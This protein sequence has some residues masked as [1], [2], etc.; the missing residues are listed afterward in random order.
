ML[1]PI[2]SCLS[3]RAL[4]VVMIA[5]PILPT[6]ALTPAILMQLGRSWHQL[7]SPT[8]LVLLGAGCGFWAV[9]V[10]LAAAGRLIRSMRALVAGGRRA[11]PRR[12]AGGT[13]A[14]A[15][16]RST[17]VIRSMA[18]AARSLGERSEAVREGGGGTAR[19]RG[20]IARLRRKRFGLVLGKRPRPSLL[21]SLRSYPHVRPGSEQPAR[22]HPLGARRRTATATP[23]NGAITG[24]CWSVTSRFAI[25]ATPE[26]SEISRSR[27]CRSAAGRS[28]MRPG[29]FSRLP[30]NRARHQRGSPRR[31][32]VARGQ[33]RGRGR[34]PR[35]IAVSRQYEPRTAHAAQRDPRFFGN[36][37]ARRR[38]IAR[39]AAAGICRLHPPE[40]CAS[41]GHHQRDPRPRQNR[42][43]QVRART[44]IAVSMRALS[45]IAASPSSAS[46]PR[47]QG[48]PSR[49]RSRP[50]CRG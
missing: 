14:R 4:L 17:T 44:R 6:L 41:A 8:E 19:Q 45:P 26:K 20:P 31:P 23:T 15:L 21:L 12:G 47:R 3:L 18:V 38:R 34:Q 40:R 35:Q 32:P 10:A 29:E 22:P 36:A 2:K 24:R 28:S 1:R 30:R 9:V 13:P 37:R 43:R 27:R 16:S 33:G 49:P 25:S 11:E 48:S 5:A 39:P 42:R 46:A 50:G 7:S